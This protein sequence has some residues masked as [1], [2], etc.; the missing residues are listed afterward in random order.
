L[1]EAACA[2]L[3]RHVDGCLADAN[4]AS[5]GVDAAADRQDEFGDIYAEAGAGGGV[6]RWDMFLRLQPAV[7]VGLREVIGRLRPLLEEVS[8][9]AWALPPLQTAFVGNR[10]QVGSRERL[11]PAG[12]ASW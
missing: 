1:S 3:R 7:L 12:L 10:Y 9:S 6:C 11:S 2:K 4:A 8:G 5:G